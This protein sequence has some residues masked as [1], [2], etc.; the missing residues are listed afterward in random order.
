MYFVFCFF[1]ILLFLFVFITYNI[2]IKYDNRVK[3]AFS[4]VDVYLKKRWELI[5][6][7]VNVT[8]GYADYENTTL[9]EVTCMR[10]SKYD[11]MSSE[12]KLKADECLSREFS[13]IMILSEDY[14]KLKANDSFNDLSAKLT[15]LEDEIANARKYYNGTIREYN[16]VVQMFPSNIVASI[17]GYKPRK[18]FVINE[19]ERQNTSFEF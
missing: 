3:D 8:K 6:N 9:R 12:D 15:K 10:G 13:K 5:P 11:E 19:K 18:M 7:L 2:L 16:N 1:V 14:P 4:V 17:F